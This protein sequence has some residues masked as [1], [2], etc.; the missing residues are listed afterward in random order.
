[1]TDWAA[2]IREGDVRSLARAATGVEN[3][4]PE[5]LE[6][7]RQL[8]PHAGHARI[9]GITGPPGAGKSTLVDALVAA[10]RETG[11]TVAIIAV[12]P[13]SHKSGGALLGDRIRMQRHHTDS[14]TFIR[15]MATRGATGGLARA[16]GDLA[17]LM[18]GAGRDYVLI[19]TVGVGQDEVEIAG[20]AQV[21]LVVLAPVMGDDVQAIKA[22]MMEIADVFV[23][24]KS[25][26][27]GADRVE[28]ELKAMLSLA[29]GDAPKPAIAR[30]VAVTGQGVAELLDIIGRAPAV[31]MRN[32]AQ[33][34]CPARIDHLGIAVRSIAEAAGFYE[35]LGFDVTHSESVPGENVTV[36]MLPA[37]DARIELLEAAGSESPIAKFLEKRG[38]GLHHVALSVPDLNGAVETL[39]SSGVRLLNEPRAGADGR[40]YIFVHP[41]SAGG[42]LLELIQ[43]SGH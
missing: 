38:Q 42:V 1:M 41:A 24:N 37:G 4:D 8:A 22:G 35:R 32:P 31:S 29:D 34:R 27:P 20:L 5:A 10:I 7:L 23:I 39:R 12:D 30:T 36:A 3:R 11:K 25:D 26:Q 13:S 19:E 16:T 9:V 2:S 43:E 40:L 6:V 21:T 33:R 28:Q 14:G 15:S 18:D 17:R